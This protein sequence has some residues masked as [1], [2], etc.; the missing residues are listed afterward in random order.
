MEGTDKD[1][2][3]AATSGLVE[4]LQRDVDL[5]VAKVLCT[6]ENLG[7][8]IAVHHRDRTNDDR[9]A[10]TQPTAPTPESRCFRA[11]RSSAATRGWVNACSQ[12]SR[13]SAA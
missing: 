10:S 9:C 13:T 6:A 11:Q 4:Q 12:T 1:V 7:D 8:T 5:I 3:V 2:V